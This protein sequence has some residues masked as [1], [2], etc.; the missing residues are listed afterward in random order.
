[1][2]VKV[3]LWLTNL[4]S[5]LLCYPLAA[6]LSSDSQRFPLDVYIIHWLPMLDVYVYVYVYVL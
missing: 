4:S 2:S 6:I 5:E 3:I 1:M